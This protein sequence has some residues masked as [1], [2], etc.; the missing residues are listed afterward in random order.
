MGAARVAARR[1]TFFEIGACGPQAV[2]AKPC[3]QKTRA[4]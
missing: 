1:L 4:V 2:K 3:G